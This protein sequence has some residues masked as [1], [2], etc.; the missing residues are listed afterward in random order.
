MQRRYPSD[1]AE[2]K[3]G[4][5]LILSL[6]ERNTSRVPEDMAF[7]PFTLSDAWVDITNLV[8]EDMDGLKYTKL[9]SQIRV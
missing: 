2:H 5:Q 7:V 1:I 9:I 3:G 4:F 8:G 6:T